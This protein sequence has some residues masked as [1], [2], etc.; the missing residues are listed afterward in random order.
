MAVL[1]A[2]DWPGNVRELENAVEHAYVTSTTGRIERQFL[3]ASLFRSTASPG[4]RDTPVRAEEQQILTVLQAHRWHKHD[5]A[6]E[7]GISRTTLWRKM[8]QMGL[9]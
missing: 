8:K 5:A 2:Y 3:P 7:L 9:E 1:M 4:E 6:L